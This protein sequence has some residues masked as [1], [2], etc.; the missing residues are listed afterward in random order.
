M[1]WKMVI[2]YAN[3]ELAIIDLRFIVEV[4]TI[5]TQESES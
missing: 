1:Q 3:W 4:P 2:S 5:L